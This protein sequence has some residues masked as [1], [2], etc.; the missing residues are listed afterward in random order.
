MDSKQRQEK[1]VTSTGEGQLPAIACAVLG[2]SA[3][4]EE[5]QAVYCLRVRIGNPISSPGVPQFWIAIPFRKY[6]A[7]R[8]CMPCAAAREQH[9]PLA[10]QATHT[11][12]A[13]AC[14]S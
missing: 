13:S 14:Q 12:Y 3:N 5:S 7:L 11:W 10:N 2:S 4:H 8:C 9:A 6:T 1:M